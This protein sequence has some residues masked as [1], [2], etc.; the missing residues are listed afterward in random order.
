MHEL[1]LADIAPWATEATVWSLGQVM[2]FLV[3]PEP[4]LAESG[5]L[6][7]LTSTKYAFL[8]HPSPR[9]A[10]PVTL[11]GTISAVLGTWNCGDCSSGDDDIYA[12]LPGEGRELLCAQLPPT[13][14]SV[15][16][17][18]CLF[19]SDAT[20][21]S[22][23]VSEFANRGTGKRLKL[24]LSASSP[25]RWLIQARLSFSWQKT[26]SSLP[27][28]RDEVLTSSC[29][30]NVA[31]VHDFVRIGLQSL[32]RRSRTSMSRFYLDSNPFYGLPLRVERINTRSSYLACSCPPAEIAE[33]AL[34]PLWRKGVHI[35]NYLDD[36]LIIAHSRDVLCEHRD[37]VLRHL[38]HLGLRVNPEK[39]KL[40]PVQ[41]ISFLGLE[42]DSVNMTAC[43]TNERT[44]SVLNCL[45][46]FR[47]KT[48]VPLKTFQRLS[49]NEE[50]AVCNDC[51]KERHSEE[52]KE[53]RLNSSA[54]TER[55]SCKDHFKTTTGNFE[56]AT[57]CCNKK[58]A[59]A[60]NST[61]SGRSKKCTAV[62]TIPQFGA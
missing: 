54:S 28:S 21:S 56:R 27:S 29:P 50:S 32:T 18:P 62:P 25:S 12:P 58:E 11:P 6:R 35:L 4:H 33:G 52:A 26:Q 23:S 57:Q 20:A 61:G 40:S 14:G 48:A 22:D 10:F 55:A 47:H 59:C 34:N 30:L 31:A 8:T 1:H 2:S 24:V 49:G 3:G 19:L 45:K 42:L 5:I 7:W 15:V 17:R 38:S 37:L 13:Y 9:L 41:R 46:P 39:S 44:Q 43:L 53:E 36:W 60:D 51:E 16:S